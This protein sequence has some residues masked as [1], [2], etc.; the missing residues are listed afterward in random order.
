[1]TKERLD[2]LIHPSPD[3][4]YSILYQKDLVFRD[5]CKD[6]DLIELLNNEELVQ[7]NAS[8]EDYYFVNIFPFLK[9]PDIQSK[10]KNFICF[11]IKDTEDLAY[12]N[13]F[14][15]RQLQFRVVSHEDDYR[16]PYM[17]ARQDIM[18]A[19]IDERFA[20]SDIFG[21]RLKKVHDTGKVA[22]NGYYYRDMY[23][24]MKPVNNLQFGHSANVMDHTG[25]TK[26]SVEESFN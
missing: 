19:L 12:N 6:S 4:N 24:E 17:M 23:Y 9:V 2:M 1:M 21:D 10:V 7:K 25:R 16:T 26:Y 8:P 22:E 14:L 3:S 18:A 11:E 15:C 13:A 20:W 5:L